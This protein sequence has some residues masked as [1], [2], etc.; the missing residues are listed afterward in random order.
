MANTSVTP[1]RV[2]PQF[3][4]DL[5]RETMR[6]SGFHENAQE[7]IVGVAK[8]VWQ[9]ERKRRGDRIQRGLLSH[10]VSSMCERL[11]EK[12]DFS[13]PAINPMSTRQVCEVIGLPGP[14]HGQ[15]ANVGCA[16]KLLTN[17]DAKR[18]ASARLLLMPPRKN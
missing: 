9:D 2:T 6:R 11:M 18:T 1:L 16:V 5:V 15:L 13:Q 3:F 7:K 8:L 14:S 10:K 17:K 12:F 4:L